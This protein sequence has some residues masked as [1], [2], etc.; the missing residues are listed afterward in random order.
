MQ[1]TYQQINT[2]A[3]K[4]TL[5]IQPAS[6]CLISVSCDTVGPVMAGSSADLKPGTGQGVLVGATPRYMV[7][8]PGDALYVY[9][10]G[11]DRVSI[12]VHPLSF[13]QRLL[14]GA[15]KGVR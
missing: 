12:A 9:S 15:V 7:L 13:L 6:W 4:T 8:D 2:E 11:T 10:S 5:L 3:G 14:Q 1:S